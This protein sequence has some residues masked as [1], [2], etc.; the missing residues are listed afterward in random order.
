LKEI[1]QVDLFK[2]RIALT[3]LEWTGEIGKID[4]DGNVKRSVNI[5]S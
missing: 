5:I 1:N 3:N 4:I 2:A